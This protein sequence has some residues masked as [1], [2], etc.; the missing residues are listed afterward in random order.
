MLQPFQQ[1]VDTVLRTFCDYQDRAVG[2]IGHRSCQLQLARC[3]LS[4]MPE[5][6]T[7]DKSVNVSFESCSHIPSK[8]RECSQ[9]QRPLK[10]VLAF[11]CFGDDHRRNWYCDKETEHVLSFP[12]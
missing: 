9:L 10:G 6:D 11:A 5:E 4:E 3:D 8:W 7:L 2:L 12:V 1:L